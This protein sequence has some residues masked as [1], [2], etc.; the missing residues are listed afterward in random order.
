[1]TTSFHR[2]VAC[3]VC[4][5]R[6]EPHAIE[7]TTATGS[8]DL[9]TRPPMMARAMLPLTVTRCSK[10]GYCAAEVAKA[11]DSARET[12]DSEA[13]RAQ[14]ANPAF[15][16]LVSTFLCASM[17]QESDGSYNSA[18]WFA[19]KAAWACDSVRQGDPTVCR[20]RALSLFRRARD[21]E[22]GFSHDAGGEEAIMADVARRAGL[23]EDVAILHDQ[24]MMRNP[25]D[26]VRAMLGFQRELAESKNTS[27]YRIQ[28][29]VNAADSP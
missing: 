18:G 17:I 26:V 2:K 25:N 1:M 14:L 7:S 4:G 23:F 6:Q 22:Q 27:C 3:A 10:C 9:D 24:G 19:L 11:P 16:E 13:Y 21:E 8:P 20:S 29:A 12:V 28:D 5:S 15:D